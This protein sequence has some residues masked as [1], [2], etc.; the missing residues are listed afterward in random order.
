[1]KTLEEPPS[2]AV[3]YD[4]SN[5]EALME[6]FAQGFAAIIKKYSNDE[7]KAI[8]IKKFRQARR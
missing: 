5:Y 1:L 2:Y 4:A 3:K 6:K 8:I 7:L